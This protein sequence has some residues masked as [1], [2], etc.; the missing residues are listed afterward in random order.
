M[1]AGD[2]PALMQILRHTPEFKPYEVAVAEE[3]IDGYLQDPKGTGYFA[4]VADVDSDVAGYICYGQTP[5]TIGTWDIFWIAVDGN[6]RGH[7]VGGALTKAAEADIKKANG[8]LIMIE[9]SSQELYEN[10]RRFYIG[11]KY[12]QVACIPDFYS[13]GDDLIMMQKRLN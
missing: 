11:Q 2:K 7:G 6:K 9:T 1:V 4:L 5:C 12:E 10:T 3:V 8:R 13:P